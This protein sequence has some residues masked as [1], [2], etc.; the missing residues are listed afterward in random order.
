MPSKTNQTN[1]ANVSA[2]Y[3]ELG[4]RPDKI[5]LVPLAIVSLMVLA[6]NT[7]VSGFHQKG[8]LDPLA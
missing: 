8:A 2:K 5:V 4:L 7:T 6:P 3:D 1:D